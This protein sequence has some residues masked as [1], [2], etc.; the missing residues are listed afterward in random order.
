MLF[1][2]SHV[3]QQK[4]KKIEMIKPIRYE[5]IFLVFV[6]KHKTAIQHSTFV[7]EPWVTTTTTTQ[8]LNKLYSSRL[9]FITSVWHLITKVYYQ[10]QRDWKAYGSVYI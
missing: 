8:S 7:K 2:S 3:F 10:A 5:L 4:K 6:N 1:I 9:S